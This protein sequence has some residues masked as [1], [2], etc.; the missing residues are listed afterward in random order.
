[1]QKRAQLQAEV[2][3]EKEMTNCYGDASMK[4]IQ[5]QPKAKQNTN[6]TCFFET[7]YKQHLF[8]VNRANILLPKGLDMTLN[9]TKHGTGHTLLY[10]TKPS[11]QKVSQEVKEDV[12]DMSLRNRQH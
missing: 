9:R 11:V 6:C 4:N 2:A 7:K 1:M 5:L 12:T 10:R 3:Q 8:Q